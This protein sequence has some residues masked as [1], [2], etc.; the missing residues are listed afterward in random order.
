MVGPLGRYGGADDW[1]LANGVTPGG[2]D[3]VPTLSGCAS[4]NDV[5]ELVAT[6]EPDA[7]VNAVG[8]FAAQLWGAGGRMAIGDAT[9]CS[10]AKR[11]PKWQSGGSPAGTSTGLKTRTQTSGTFAPS[12]GLGRTSAVGNQAG[13]PLLAWAFSTYCQVSRNEVAARIAA[14]AAN[15]SDPGSKV[16]VKPSVN[17]KPPAHP[18]SSLDGDSEGTGRR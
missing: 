11:P 18:D 15:G 1:A 12:S 17:P 7:S 6:A 16:A 8:N 2:F 14:I 4:L 9:S 10:L 3:K 13:P 5:R